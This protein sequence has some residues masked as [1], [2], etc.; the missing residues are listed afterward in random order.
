MASTESRTAV[1]S[2]EASCS[3]SSGATSRRQGRAGVLLDRI[4]F[5]PLGE[6]KE[7]ALTQT[8]CFG[9]ATSQAEL[10][11]Q[12]TYSNA[13]AVTGGMGGLIGKT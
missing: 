7:L 12:E 6:K 8:F 10:M 5:S 4:L 1:T 3:Q 11:K 2:S 13:L 9:S